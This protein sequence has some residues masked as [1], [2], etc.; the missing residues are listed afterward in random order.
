MITIRHSEERGRTKID[1]LDSYHTF[2]FGGYRDFAHMG[3]GVLR[4]INDD[5]VAPGQGFHTHGHKDMEIITYVLEGA[6]SLQ[7]VVALFEA[8]CRLIPAE[9]QD[10]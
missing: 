5:I 4:V 7:Q 1:W 8:V 2:S 3:F 10:H 6:L 9:A